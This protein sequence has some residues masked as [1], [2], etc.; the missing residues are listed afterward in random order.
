MVALTFALGALFLGL[1]SRGDP[2]QRREREA[3]GRVVAKQADSAQ[4]EYGVD[5]P[6]KGE[7]RIKGQRLPTSF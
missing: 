1:Q 5:R 3:R 4:C 6:R 2:E 7:A